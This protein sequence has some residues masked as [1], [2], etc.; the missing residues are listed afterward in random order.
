[1]AKQFLEA[2]EV[3]IKKGYL[4]VKG[5]KVQPIFNEKF[6]E[7]QRYAEYVITFAEKAKDKDFNGKEAD[8]LQAVINEAR[9]ALKAPATTYLKE[10]K[11]PEN[12]LQKQLKEEAL[13]FI[14]Y[15][16]SKEV[17]E[18]V[19]NYMQRFNSIQE[20]EEVGLFFEEDIVKLNK[21]YT[22]KDIVKAVKSIIDLLD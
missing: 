1:M 15:E 7:A 12:T 21:I 20:F 8:N 9:E 22:I 10:P 13:D 16:E 2:A 5:S 14:S 3:E 19:N 18:K 17:N 4:S 11:K 6:V